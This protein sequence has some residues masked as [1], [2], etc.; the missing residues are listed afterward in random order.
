MGQVFSFFLPLHVCLTSQGPTGAPGPKGM[1]GVKGELGE[2]VIKET[3]LNLKAI[4]GLITP[5]L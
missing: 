1:S 2:Q 3:C 5:T 4:I